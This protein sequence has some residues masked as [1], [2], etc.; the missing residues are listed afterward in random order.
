MGKKIFKFGCLGIIGFFVFMM[1]VVAIFAPKSG[2]D[3]GDT[4]KT[5]TE[6]KQETKVDKQAAYQEILQILGSV[7]QEKDDVEQQIRYCT[8]GD[9]YQPETA[10]HYDVAVKDKYIS[11]VVIHVVHFS[12]D[13]NWVFWDRMTFANNGTKWEKDIASFAGQSGGGKHTQIVMGGKYEI[14]KGSI[15]DVQE[16]LKVL[17]NGDNPILRLSGK[18][19]YDMHPTSA[20]LA[21]VRDAL[22]LEELIQQMDHTLP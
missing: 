9:M 6:Q 1:L 11:D 19:K 17:V 3:G 2:S 14:W 4:A 18:Y 22:R 13:T 16:G 8:F 5:T 20:D 15:E 10:I 12:S 21:R 7:P